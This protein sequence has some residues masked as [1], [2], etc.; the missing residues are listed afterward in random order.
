LGGFFLQEEDRDADSDPNTS[1]GVF[2]YAINATVTV[3]T[4]D[5]VC[6]A[7]NVAEYKGL[8]E[9]KNVTEIDVCESVALPSA[10]S[11]TLPID[12]ENALESA[13]GMRVLL[14]QKLTVTDTYGLGRYGEITLSNGRL[15]Q[16]HFA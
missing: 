13:E 15:F 16:S 5:L 7:G 4:G 2:V 9:I 6:V 12:S 11:I 8:T 14:P 3:E 10:V 1:E